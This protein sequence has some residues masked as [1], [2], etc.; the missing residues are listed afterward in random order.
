MFDKELYR[1]KAIVTRVVDGDTLDLLLDLG[2][3]TLRKER[4]RLYGIDTPESYGAKRCK[5]GFEAKEKVQELMTDDK[6]DYKE[7][8]VR[9]HKKGKY[10][11]YLAQIWFMQGTKKIELNKYLVKN[12][13]A[14][15][16]FGGKR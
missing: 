13:Y 12:G 16:Y 8:L 11:R 4:V 14:K 10:G 5:A 3:S 9:T 7:V 2:C 6:G 1:Y 15:E